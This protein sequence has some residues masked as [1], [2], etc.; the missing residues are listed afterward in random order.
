MDD[1][2]RGQ[3]RR[4]GAPAC[5]GLGLVLLLAV[6]AAYKLLPGQLPHAQAMIGDAAYAQCLH[7]TR[8]AGGEGC[9]GFGYPRGAP[10]PFGLP[11]NLLAASLFASDGVV[12]P[13]EVRTV[14][15]GIVGLA[16]VLA[17]LLFRRV[18]GSRVAGVLGAGL[19]LL[20]PALQQQSSFAALQLG[21]ALIPG[22]LLL[23]VLLLDAL[24]AGR[25]GRAA[26]LAALVAGVRVFALFLDGYS[27]LFAAVLSTAYLGLAVLLPRGGSRLPAVLALVTH[28]ACTGL[29]AWIYARYL[30][31]GLAVMPVDFFRGAGVDVLTM[32]APMQSQSLYGALGLGLDIQPENSWG[33][34]ASLLGMF[35]G[36]SAMVA[37]G[38]L[39][40]AIATRRARRPGLLPC[41]ILLTGLAATLL[42]LGP[43]LK[44]NDFRHD[45]TRVSALAFSAYL[46]PEAAATA[47]LHSG[48]IYQAVPGIRNARVLGR[49]QVLAR[50]ALVTVTLLALV[51][52]WRSGKR[53]PAVAL[54]AFA[55][56]EAMPDPRLVGEESRAASDRAD[57]VY[58]VHGGEFARL[59]QPGE[60]VLLLQMHE[61]ASGNEFAAD[62]FCAL[63]RAHCYNTGG[64][65]AS[66]AIRAAWPD[67]IRAAIERREVSRNVREAFGKGLVDVVVVPHF[68]LRLVVYPW[69]D[70]VPDAAGI[71]EAV[72]AAFGGAGLDIRAASGFTVIRACTAPACVQ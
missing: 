18:S 2:G 70:E 67:E 1:R 53:W 25:R 35:V 41:A 24:R 15:A 59:V 55:L 11:V 50:L 13:G 19:Y 48:W 3:W 28:V 16:F 29:A 64:D 63:A 49:W 66:D 46:M 10:R 68:D 22:Y 4:M 9:L 37:A 69:S 71:A 58:R 47:R 39:A 72:D 38:L 12:S 7:D 8:A 14:Y 26:A 17:A 61:G 36:Y 44:F 32:L 65:K 62:T 33:G 51:V 21:L 60:R 34:R 27:F 30:P 52:L 23:D 6:L 54:A 42:S 31:G 45:H 43:S 56:F 20:A 40:W 5:W 57:Q